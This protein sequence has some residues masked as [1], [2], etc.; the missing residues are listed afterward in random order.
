MTVKRKINIAVLFIL[1]AA[2]LA[3]KTVCFSWE[4]PDY[5]NRTMLTT[6]SGIYYVLMLLLCFFAGREKGG[7]SILTCVFLVKL[8]LLGLTTLTLW[9]PLVV[10]F[11]YFAASHYLLNE[12]VHSFEAVEE[13]LPD[14][15]YWGAFALVYLCFTAVAWLGNKIEKREKV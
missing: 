11:R 1:L 10:V 12:A 7:F 15:I 5:F 2:V 4:Y 6:F 14:I 3:V 13:T 9:E 8:I